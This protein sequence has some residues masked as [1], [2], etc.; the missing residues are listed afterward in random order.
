MSTSRSKRRT[1]RLGGPP[2]FIPDNTHKAVYK[3]ADTPKNAVPCGKKLVSISMPGNVKN[4]AQK[5]LQALA[6]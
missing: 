2:L 3:T 5:S 1:A 6:E 4:N